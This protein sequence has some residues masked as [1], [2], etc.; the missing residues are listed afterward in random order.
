VIGVAPPMRDP[1]EDLSRNPSQ[2]RK[3]EVTK[4]T[5]CLAV[6]VPSYFAVSFLQSPLS[7]SRHSSFQRNAHH[8]SCL[9]KQTRGINPTTTTHFIVTH[10]VISNTYYLSLLHLGLTDLNTRASLGVLTTSS[11][12]VLAGRASPIL[13]H[14]KD[15]TTMVS[16]LNFP[17]HQMHVVTFDGYRRQSFRFQG[18]PIN[19]RSTVEVDHGLLL[20]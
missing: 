1:Y 9:F 11:I 7:T 17:I 14:K 18:A 13:L 6:F 5:C 19:L 10:S 12:F 2:P 16:V 20:T 15:L 4:V 3:R 8:R